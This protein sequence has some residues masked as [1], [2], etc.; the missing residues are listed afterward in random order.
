MSWLYIINIEKRAAR[1][2]EMF[3]NWSL[4][5]KLLFVSTVKTKFALPISWSMTHVNLVYI[6]F[7]WS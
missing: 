7:S 3:R 6:L 5:V 2:V 4:Y 1:F